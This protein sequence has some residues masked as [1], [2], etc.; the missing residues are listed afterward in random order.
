MEQQQPDGFP[1]HF[2][3]QSSFHRLFGHQ[4]HCPARPAPRRL[5]AN[6]GD[7]AFSFCG[8]QQRYRARALLVI[9]S[10]VQS[11]LLVTA[12]NLTHGFGCQGNEGCHLGS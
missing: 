7:D 3:D 2:R 4:T 10:L 1:A 8:L 9:K 6:H 5:A 12:A 11:R